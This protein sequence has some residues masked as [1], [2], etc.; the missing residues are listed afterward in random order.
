MSAREAEV[1]RQLARMRAG[2]VDFVG[3]EELRARLLAAL[4]AGRPLRV[5][6]GMDPSAPD[7][8]LGHSVTLEKLRVFQEL[9]HTPVF[10]VGDFTARIG[11]PTGRNRTRRALD[12][13]EVEA[14]ARTYI[15][16]VSRV[17]GGGGD[18]DDGGAREGAGGDSR[19]RP[20]G[21]PQRD[22]SS[23]ARAEFEVRFNSEW[24]GALTPADF[25]RL[26][27]RYTVARMLERDDFAKRMR[28]GVAISVHEFLYPLLQA[29]DSVMLKA[30]IE[31]GG[32]DQLFNLL[33]GREIQRDYGQAPQ[34][35]LTHPL[36]VGTDGAR[37]MSK[38]LGNTVGVTDAPEEMYG[39][40]MSISDALMGDWCAQ[41]SF[42]RWDDLLARAAAGAE[43]LAVKQELARRIV[44]RFHGGEAA[45]AAAAH[46]QRVVQRG[47]APEEIPECVL[48]A[49][50][51][52]E[53]GLLEA[54]R[55]AFAL[56][57]NAEA[58]RL[59]QQGAVQVDGARV[60]DAG[61]RLGAGT[62]LLRAGKRR[63]ARVHIR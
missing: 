2:V 28:E 3:E 18:G 6:L 9:G 36:L 34:A 1:E 14:N 20:C 47:E 25:V 54:L 49:G 42:G 61:A 12:A 45:V 50:D 32:A 40:A 63:Y 22:A 53:R 30:D 44:E 10:L 15:E 4:E 37:K 51:G 21:P 46:F 56:A 58:R 57:S 5:K 41:L 29:Y 62:H 52:G 8:H 33:V 43:P 27:S 31:L 55:R 26:C 7:L 38:S 39:R 23:R 11:D 48:A 17:L 13:S 16:Q 24:L 19:A 59:V 35:V 60:T